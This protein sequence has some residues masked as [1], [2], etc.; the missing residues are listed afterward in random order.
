M[1]TPR[2]LDHVEAMELLEASGVG[3]IAF[4]TEA[5][6]EIYP[7]NYSVDSRAIYFR[8]SPHSQLG[9]AIDGTD[10]A[11]EIDHLNWT[12]RQ[13]WSV[14][15]KGRAEVVDDPAEIARIRE[16]R[17]EPQPWASGLRRLYVRVPVK[18]ISGREVGNEWIGESRPRE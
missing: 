8:T 9:T 3:R 5:G 4:C 10:V 1:T 17:H 2:E 6:P 14:V 15:V 7:V 13:G 12:S 11:F 18:E 16:R